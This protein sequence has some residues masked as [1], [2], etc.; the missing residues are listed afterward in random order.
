MQFTGGDAITDFKGRERSLQTPNY[1]KKVIWLSCLQTPQLI[2]HYP[3]PQWVCFPLILKIVP[4]F[5][6][7]TCQLLDSQLRNFPF[8][9]FS[10]SSMVKCSKTW[11]MDPRFCERNSKGNLA[12]TM[13]KELCLYLSHRHFF[14]NN[15][16]LT[17]NNELCFAYHYYIF[18]SRS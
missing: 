1:Y 14:N 5:V 10:A 17:I 7:P 11:N 15:M 13:L 6:Y 9:H 12:I 18:Y 4:L 2:T 3:S 8:S 16:H